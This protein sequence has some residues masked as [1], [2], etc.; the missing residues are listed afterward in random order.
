MLTL[1]KKGIPKKAATPAVV[2]IREGKIHKDKKK[3]QVE[4][5]KDKGKNKLAYAFKPKIPPSPKRENLVNDS[6]CH[7]CKEVGYWRRNCP[8][9]HVELNKR[10]NA[11]KASTP[12]IFTIELYEFPNKSWVYDTSCGTYICNT[13]YGLRES[14]KLKHGALSLYVGNRMRYLKETMGYYFYYLLENK[15]FVARNDDIFENNLILK[16]VSGS[17]GLLTASGSN[18][19]LEL[20]QE[21][22]TQPFKNTS[23]RHEEV[24]PAEVEPYSMEVPIHRFGR[25]SQA[26]D[27]YG[28]Y[29]DVEEH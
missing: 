25:I 22:D 17:H 29:V 19:G 6:V 12:S 23:D 11:G 24:E 16:E 10:K 1:H 27:R 15:I 9:Y 21:D 20:I 13:S 4:N 3:P 18:I 8:S 7:H 2:T 5:G 28:F 14:R 26:P